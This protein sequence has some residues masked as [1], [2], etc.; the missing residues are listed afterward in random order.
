MRPRCPS[1]SPD[2][3]GLD[4]LKR[5][6][7]S[8]TEAKPES[9]LDGRLGEHELHYRIGLVIAE[10]GM[11][12]TFHGKSAKAMNQRMAATVISGGWR[13]SPPLEMLSEVGYPQN[14][15]VPSLLMG[16]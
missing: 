5:V 15:M 16:L 11:C 9:P 2:C 10:Y 12:L 14:G 3:H 1:A 7:R 13:E 6:C 8:A 4:L